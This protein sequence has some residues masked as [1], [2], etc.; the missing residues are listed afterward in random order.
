MGGRKEEAGRERRNGGKKKKERIKRH[1]ICSGQVAQL[2]KVL[3]Q[4]VKVAGSIPGQG[5]YKNQPM[6]A[7]IS[8]ATK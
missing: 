7:Q 8:G 2:V 5:T 6:N 1:I 4:Y 3:F